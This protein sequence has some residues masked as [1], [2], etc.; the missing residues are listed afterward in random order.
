MLIKIR[1]NDTETVWMKENFSKD[2][3]KYITNYIKI[4]SGNIHIDK[5][6]KALV[7]NNETEINLIRNLL[8]NGIFST[9][10]QQK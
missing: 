5:K 3:F 10:E 8:N 4:I 6:T 2:K 1:Y 7:C 9:K